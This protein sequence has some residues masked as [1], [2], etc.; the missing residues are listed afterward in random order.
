[1]NRRAYALLWLV[2]EMVYHVEVVLH[3][4]Y[5][6]LVITYNSMVPFLN[7][8]LLARFLPGVCRDLLYL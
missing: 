7:F 5:N 8:V 4:C 3:K 1:M 6:G 2:V